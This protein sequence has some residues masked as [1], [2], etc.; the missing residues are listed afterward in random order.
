M[1]DYELETDPFYFNPDT[2]VGL[3]KG[4]S[5]VRNRLPVVVK[6]HD[7][8]L[9]QQKGTQIRMVQAINAA[10]AQAKVQHPTPAT[11]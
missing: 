9:I 7:F 3:F 4:V 5:L 1:E 8:N 10:L 6:R 11:S 2:S